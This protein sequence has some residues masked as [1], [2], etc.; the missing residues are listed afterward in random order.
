M[1]GFIFTFL[2]RYMQ[3]L[4]LYLSLDPVSPMRIE[5]PLFILN[6]ISHRGKKCQLTEMF[7]PFINQ[8]KRGS[9]RPMTVARSPDFEN[10]SLSI[11]GCCFKKENGNLGPLLSSYCKGVSLLKRILLTFGSDSSYLTWS[12]Y[13]FLIIGVQLK[14][15]SMIKTL[16]I[17]VPM[18]MLFYIFIKSFWLW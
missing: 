2:K 14:T 15:K 4:S 13:G 11:F 16:Y 18:P 3:F 5:R 7:L 9:K 1:R 6:K 10:F 12:P 17:W 8:P